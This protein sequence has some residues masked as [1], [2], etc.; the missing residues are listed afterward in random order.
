M[1]PAA[2]DAADFAATETLRDGRRAEIR[3]Y[4]PG[5]REALMAAVARMSSE[6]LYR[7]FFTVKR[8]F[9]ERERDFFLNVD[10]D[11]QVALVAV[12]EEAGGKV[13]VGGGRY[14]RLDP[15]RAEVAFVVID[16][17]QGLGIG[18]AL[19]RHLAAIASAARLQELVAEV[20]PENRPMLKVFANSGLQMTETEQDEVVH[21]TLALV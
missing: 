21:V 1:P 10:F 15:V 2:P 11:T 6:S 17:Y 18:A 9:S 14:V 4:A 16:A 5:D 3:A 19:M 12:M 8:Q 20:L 13:I 7:R